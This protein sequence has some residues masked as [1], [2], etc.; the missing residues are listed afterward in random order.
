MN[1]CIEDSDCSTC[2]QCVT[3]C[4]TGALRERND[5]PEVFKVLADPDKITVVQVAPAVRSAW[6]EDMNMPE[7]MHWTIV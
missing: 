5:V 7:E 2:G 1:R 4:P 3:H 6:A